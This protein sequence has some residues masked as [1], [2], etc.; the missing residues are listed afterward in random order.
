M[1]TLFQIL[2]LSLG[3]ILGLILLPWA[4]F[5]LAR[6]SSASIG[7]IT[8]MVAGSFQS[9]SQRFGSWQAQRTILNQ[10]ANK[11]NSSRV[12]FSRTRQTSPETYGM[13]ALLKQTI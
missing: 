6:I 12:R 3:A 1:E 7:S 9:A 13:A 8:G 11:V 4:I 10:A 5:V 2:L